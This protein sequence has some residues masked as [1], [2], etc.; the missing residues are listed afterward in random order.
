MSS[1]RRRR[2]SQSASAEAIPIPG[3]RARQASSQEIAIPGARTR[4]SPEAERMQIPRPAARELPITG[5]AEE[6]AVELTEPGAEP[7]EGQMRDSGEG[8][9]A[10][11]AQLAQKTKAPRKRKAPAKSKPHAAKKR[12]AD[13]NETEGG[14][15]AEE[16]DN[17]DEAE[18]SGDDSEGS[19]YEEDREGEEGERRARKAIGTAKVP[20]KKRAKKSGPKKKPGRKK[21]E[22]S[23][24]DGEERRIEE[25]TM[26]MRDLCRDPHI[27]RKSK[28]FVE[29]QQMDWTKIVREQR[30]A[31][32]ELEARRAAGEHIHVETTDE[33]LT[34]LANE[35]AAAASAR[36]YIHP[37]FCLCLC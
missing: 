26:K 19:Q 7:F 14:E 11:A 28:R 21:R 33:R 27:G 36:V 22:E 20:K 17:E 34:R 35:N 37:V 1:S 32:A 29:I 10:A 31:K 5:P 2:D 9:S 30:A 23:P 8:S 24:E 12:K 15:E 18:P 4:R 25:N 6:G 16:E 13:S 3:Q